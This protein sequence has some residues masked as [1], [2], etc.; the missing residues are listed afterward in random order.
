[1]ENYFC[2]VSI[3]RRT[4][5][6]VLFRDRHLAPSMRVALSVK[7]HHTKIARSRKNAQT[8]RAA[9][10]SHS[11][12]ESIVR[13]RICS[14]LPHQLYVSILSSRSMCCWC[15][16]CRI[17]SISKPIQIAK[18]RWSHEH[19]SD[20]FDS[21][22]LPFV[23]RGIR[24]SLR[25]SGKNCNSDDEPL[26]KVLESWDTR[27]H[28]FLSFSMYFSRCRHCKANPYPNRSSAENEP[29]DFFVITLL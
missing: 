4:F 1:M 20:T 13:E 25:P 12:M 24:P 15:C 14:L 21:A 19:I 6:N 26:S 29:T 11:F 10:T 16:C 5:W 9:S 27:S 17:N 18:N 2:V 8:A 22:G 3:L 28:E 7:E 23:S